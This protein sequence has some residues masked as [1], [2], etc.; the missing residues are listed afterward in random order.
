MPATYMI[1]KIPPEI[2]TEA[3][4]ANKAGQSYTIHIEGVIGNPDDFE[5]SGDVIPRKAELPLEIPF[6]E[7]V[8][9]TQATVVS[10]SDLKG[11]K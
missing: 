7:I 9:L 2:L 10:A 8:R 1:V 6:K 4:A 11:K 5:D 3:M